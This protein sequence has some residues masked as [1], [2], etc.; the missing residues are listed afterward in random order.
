M[1]F[2]PFRAFSQAWAKLF[3]W[4]PESFHEISGY[5]YG[6]RFY[7]ARVFSWEQ[8]LLAHMLCFSYV[9]RPHLNEYENILTDMT[10]PMTFS[11][12]ISLQNTIALTSRNKDIHIRH[13]SY[14]VPF[15][16]NFW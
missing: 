7:W 12:I 14:C 2:E 13:K 5:L 1:L 3:F 8:M 15:F 10:A 6:I 16:Y 4:Y 11:H 9:I